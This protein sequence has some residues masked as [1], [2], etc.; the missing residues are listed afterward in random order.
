MPAVI[1]QSSLSLSLTQLLHCLS[2]L[3]VHSVMTHYNAASALAIIAFLCSSQEL[4][5]KGNDVFEF[6]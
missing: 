2:F 6:H 3:A 5:M 1:T 4:A